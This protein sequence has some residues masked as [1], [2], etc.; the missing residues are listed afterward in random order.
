MDNRKVDVFDPNCYGEEEFGP[1]RDTGKVKKKIRRKKKET[2][3]ILVFGDK[4][5]RQNVEKAVKESHN[6]KTP[7]GPKRK[8]AVLQ[9]KPLPSLPSVCQIDSRI[10]YSSDF[11]VGAQ[12]YF[13]SGTNM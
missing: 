7:G 12:N 9:T 6:L 8:P 11:S 2:K 13:D 1:E 5:Q 10:G 3:A 4:G